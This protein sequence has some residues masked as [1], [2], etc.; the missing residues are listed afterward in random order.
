LSFLASL[1]GLGDISKKI[2][3]I[4][5]KIQAPINKAIDWVLEKVIKLAQGIIKF[6]KDTVQKIK[7]W[8]NAKVEFTLEN[9]HHELSFKGQGTS[10]VLMM[11]SNNPAEFMIETAFPTF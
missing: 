1:L 10:A 7:D 9:E 6:G 2:R 8:W 3:E 11:A 4:I 5:E